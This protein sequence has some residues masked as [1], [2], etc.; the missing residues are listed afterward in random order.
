MSLCLV[1]ISKCNFLKISETTLN[2]NIKV[3][4]M[5]DYKVRNKDRNIKE[6]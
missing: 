6:D 5:V 2:R 4:Q 1:E 3:N